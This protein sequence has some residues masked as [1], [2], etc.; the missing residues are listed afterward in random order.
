MRTLA[1]VLAMLLLYVGGALVVLGLRANRR[2]GVRR[3]RAVLDAEGGEED[4]DRPP[5]AAVWSQLT[6][7]TE[8]VAGEGDLLS[9]IGHLLDRAG[10]LF[11]PAEYLII[12]V[13]TAIGGAVLGGLLFGG[14]GAAVLAAVGGAAPFFIAS[15]RA[16]RA[17]K[18]V[19][20][21]LPE[22]LDQLG[23]AVRSGYS[24]PQGIE[25][26][27][28][29]APPPLGPQLARVIAETQVGRSLDT[30]LEAMADRL[31]SND[32][33]WSVRAMIIQGRTGGRLSDILE[34]LAE[35]MRDREEVRR[36]VSALTADGRI[37]ALVLALLPFGI[38]GLIA[39]IRPEYLTPLFTETAGRAIMGIAAVLLVAAII[40]MRN[41]VDIE[42]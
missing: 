8:D 15:F 21:Q 9:R 31:G 39:A 20:A 35:F 4:D 2:S 11:R 27:A 13:A 5:L 33:R 34:V 37:S 10:F 19:E 17:T 6:R 23:A 29:A 30:A 32:L 3:L 7:F 38:G 18:R 41:I 28:N 1:I 24:L 14:W 26:V 16:N 40:W 22:V 42:V 12:A 25:A 36:E